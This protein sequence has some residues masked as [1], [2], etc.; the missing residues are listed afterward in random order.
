M[1]ALPELQELERILELGRGHLEAEVVCEVSAAH[2]RFPV[3]QICLG[4]PDPALPAIGFF[5]GIHGLERIGTQVLLSFLRG[6]LTRL[7]W[8]KSLHHL[9]QDVRLVFMPLINPGGMWQSTRCNPQ[10]VDLMRNAPVNA[11]GKV[12][13]LVGGH[14]ISRHLPW[15]RGAADAGME[16]ENQALCQVV[17]KE[18]LGRSFSMAIDCHSGFGLRDRIWFPHAHDVHP[19]PHLADILSLEELFQQT[20]PNHHYLFEPQSLQ[21]QTHGDVWDYLYLQSQQHHGNTFLPLTLE[22]GSWLWVKKNPRQLFS[23]H[24][25]FNPIAEHRLQR[26]LRR[27]NSWLDFLM[28]ATCGHQQWLAQGPSRLRLQE[29]AVARWYRP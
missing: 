13:F 7:T 17:Q 20:H 8:D 28:R 3:Y 12:P 22:M 25:M 29:R 1:A 24:G 18:L 5:G 2:Q 14:R 11:E 21:Y 10:G 6:L 9:L 27:H 16:V 26:V 4:N 19:I 15:Y 23:R